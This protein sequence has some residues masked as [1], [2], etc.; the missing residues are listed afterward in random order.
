M[1]E[2]GLA[3]FNSIFISNVGIMSLSTSVFGGIMVG[4]LVAYLY[5]KFKSIQ[6]P[7]I[8]GFFSGVRFIPIVTFTASLVLGMF[9]S[10][11]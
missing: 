3:Q 1:G 8:I 9:I 2:S 6:L 7:S 4:F 11:V 5:N 10:M